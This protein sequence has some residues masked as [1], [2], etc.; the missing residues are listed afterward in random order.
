MPGAWYK[1]VDHTENDET[2]DNTKHSRALSPK[3]RHFRNSRDFTLIFFKPLSP[4]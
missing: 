1:I 4:I 2:G 3:S